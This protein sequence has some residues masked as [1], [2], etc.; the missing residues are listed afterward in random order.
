[1]DKFNNYYEMLLFLCKKYKNKTL[2]FDEK[3]KISYSQFLNKVQKIRTFL[4][5]RGV[6]KGDKVALMVANS[7]EFIICFF[8]ITSLGGIAVPINIF[9]KEGEVAYILNDCKAKVMFASFDFKKSLENIKSVSCVEKIIWIFK[10]GIKNENDED[11]IF[12]EILNTKIEEFE[13]DEIKIDDI[14][15]IIYTSGTSGNPKGAMLSYKNVFS[16]LKD[17]TEILH[18]KD[19]DRFIVYLPMFHSFT[20]TVSVILPIYLG[21]SMVLVKSVFPFSNVLKQILLKRVTCFLG[22]PAIYTALS[23]AKIPWY[24]RWFNKIRLFICGSAPLAKQTIDDFNK[25]FPRAMLSEGYGLSECSP[26]VSVNTKEHN[27]AMSVGKPLPSCSVKIVDENMMEV[28]VGDI[29]EIII[30]GDNVM[31]GYLNMPEVNDITIV[32]GWLRT[33]DLGRVDEDEYLY[34]VDRLKDLIISKGINIYPREIEEVAKTLEQIESV[35]AI[36]VKNDQNDE[37]VALFVQLRDGEKLEKSAIKAHLKANL[38]N[39]KLPKHIYITKKLPTNATGKV[40]KRVL[41]AKFEEFA[42]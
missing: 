8:A 31:Q 34:I 26:V 28:R 42:K 14:A 19:S 29:G 15:T 32:N 5:E 36:G 40:L 9:L 16:N 4:N 3:D 38:A 7:S 27:R 21:G 33:G 35:A 37:D 41:K 13:I 2:I 25:K 39:Y 18:L 22:I 12:S 6:K 17:A 11:F 20:L 24:F 30:K 10:D 1:M 23:K